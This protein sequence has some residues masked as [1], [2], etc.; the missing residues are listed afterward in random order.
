M[1]VWLLES[2]IT[3]TESKDYETETW[4]FETKEKAKAFIREEFFS[5]TVR[6]GR[7][8]V[9]T[10]LQTW[11]EETIVCIEFDVYSYI[12]KEVYI[13]HNELIFREITVI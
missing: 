10:N 5:S 8:E 2:I 3:E 9:I 11:E 13:Y 12:D 4:V 6:H 7:S 1:K